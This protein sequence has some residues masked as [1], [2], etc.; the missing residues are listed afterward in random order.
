[1]MCVCVCVCARAYAC[2][3]V[4]V[5]VCARARMCVCVCV[6]VCARV[7][8]CV[9][10]PGEQS[11]QRMQEELAAS[12]QALAQSRAEEQALT[13]KVEW[14]DRTKSALECD[15]GLPVECVLLL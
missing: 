12:K 5:C 13:D 9:R 11:N 8:V 14:L 1:M 4:C 10:I 7:C 6:C 3:C 15:Q 2:V